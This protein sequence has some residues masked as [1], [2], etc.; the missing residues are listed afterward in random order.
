MSVPDGGVSNFIYVRSSTST[1]GPVVLTDLISDVYVAAL[2]SN[3]YTYIYSAFSTSLVH[4]YVVL[5]LVLTVKRS[6]TMHPVAYCQQSTVLRLQHCS[7]GCMP[8]LVYILILA[9]LML[10]IRQANKADGNQIAMSMPYQ[11]QIVSSLKGIYSNLSSHSKGSI[12][13]LIH[14]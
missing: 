5:L 3:I 2:A 6:F 7:S 9:A 1:Y 12:H 11:S 10:P 4:G 8:L 14:I 13:R